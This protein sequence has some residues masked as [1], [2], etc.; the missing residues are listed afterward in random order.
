VTI[1][2][3]GGFRVFRDERLVPL[4]A[5]Q[6]KKA[7][8]L[9]KL[10]V[11]RRGRPAPRDCLIEAL[12]PDEDPRKAANRLSVALSTVRAVLDP[13]RRF[14]PEHYVAAGREAV[15]LET[16]NV[17]LDLDTFFA[18][19]DSGLALLR[20]GC[21]REAHAVLAQAEEAYA[22]DFLEEDLYED[23]AAGPREEARVVYIA[24]ARALI[25]LSIVFGDHVAASRYALRILERDSYDADA[26]LRLISCLAAARAHGEARRAY[27]RYAGR[28]A[29]IGVAP[30]PLARVLGERDQSR[31]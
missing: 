3:L 15:A 27:R 10:L 9:L 18:Q 28:M 25:D 6:S 8:D 11:A 14:G 7:R 30:V 4:R 26:H 23:W 21:D 24:V 12:W 2:A 13:E 16:T 1:R 29:E 5:W 22:G 20:R 17:S 31:L 19:A